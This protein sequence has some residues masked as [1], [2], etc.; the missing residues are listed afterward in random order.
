MSLIILICFVVSYVAS[1]F[2]SSLN[3]IIIFGFTLGYYMGA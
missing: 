2:A 1:I 3:S